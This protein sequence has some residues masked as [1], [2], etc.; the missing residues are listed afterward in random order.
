MRGTGQKSDVARARGDA[1]IAAAPGGS[2][3]HSCVAGT[4]TR[5]AKGAKLVYRSQSFA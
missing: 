1:E 3:G 5:A 4:Q 2:L